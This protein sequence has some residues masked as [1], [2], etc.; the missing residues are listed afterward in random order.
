MSDDEP[1]SY[2][3]M[4]WGA[5]DESAITVI[6]FFARAER[7]LL[8]EMGVPA[9]LLEVHDAPSTYTHLRDLLDHQERL[10]APMRERWEAMVRATVPFIYAA[11]RWQPQ[12]PGHAGGGRAA[13]RRGQ[14]RQRRAVYRDAKLLRDC[15]ALARAA[16]LEGA[17]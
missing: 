11:A 14:A 4:D 6:E 7:R 2:I 15:H 10:L 5:G 8:A 1:E 12:R 9:A 16:G 13:R 3:G 17:P